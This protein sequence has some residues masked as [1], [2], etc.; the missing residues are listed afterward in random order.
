[1]SADR[2]LAGEADRDRL[3]RAVIELAAREGWQSLSAEEVA[4]RAGVSS[5]RFEEIFGGLE[6]CLVAAE[7][8]VVSDVLSVV[9]GTYSP[10]RSDHDN[11]ILGMKAILEYFAANP[12]RAYFGY[13]TA[14]YGAPRAVNEA[15][16]STRKML[17]A[18]IN[19][20]RETA[21]DNPAPASA[22]RAALGAADAIVKREIVAG[23]TERLAELLPT[24]IYATTVPFLGQ[25]EA[26]RMSGRAR[27]LLAREDGKAGPSESGRRTA[28]GPGGRWA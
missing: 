7:Q 4:Q 5:G 18:M 15:A 9:S 3:L 24:L 8:T 2:N 19:R 27:T 14:S 6:E 10:D 23:R 20:L 22:A 1:M 28:G 21:G 26:V 12:E 13:I 16:E 11:G 17:A 25:S